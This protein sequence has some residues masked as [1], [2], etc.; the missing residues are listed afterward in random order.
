[1]DV[2]ALVSDPAKRAAQEADELNRLLSN[3]Q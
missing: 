1:M 3:G 2:Y